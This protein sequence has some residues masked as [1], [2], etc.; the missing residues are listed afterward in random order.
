MRITC[1]CRG[2]A[3][4]IR[5]E[6]DPIQNEFAFVA[7]SIF[8]RIA[9]QKCIESLRALV[10]ERPIRNIFGIRSKVVSYRVNGVL[11]THFRKM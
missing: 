11:D 7:G 1:V 5:Y 3:E 6:S 4:E 10:N 9:D 8:M 2:R